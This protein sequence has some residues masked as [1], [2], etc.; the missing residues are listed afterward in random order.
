MEKYRA[1]V[2]KTFPVSLLLEDKDCLIVGGGQGIARKLENMIHSGARLTLISPDLS[3]STRDIINEN[4]ISWI[5][6]EFV[7]ADLE[8]RDLVYTGT[9][10]TE[11]NKKVLQECKKRRILCCP[12]DRNWP[13]GDFTTPAIFRKDELS[14]AVSTGGASCRRSKLI[15][16]SLAKHVDMI[17]SAQLL[18]IGTSHNHLDLEKREAFHLND[19]AIEKTG[20]MLNHVWGV[21]EFLILNTCNRI[22]ILAIVSNDKNV[23]SL[24]KRILGFDALNQDEYYIHA[25]EKAFH[26]SST[27]LAGLYSQTPGENHIV[28]QVKDALTVSEKMGWAGTILKDWISRSLGISKKIRNQTGALLKDLEIED[29]ALDYIEEMGPGKKR[30]MILGTGVI[31][32][33]VSERALKKGHSLISCYYRNNPYK[34]D[35]RDI[36]TIPLTDF[37]ERLKDID[38]LIAAT[39]SQNFLLNIEDRS[40]FRDSGKTILIDLSLPRNISPALEDRGENIQI[41]DLDD[42][43]H[44]FRREQADMKKIMTICS[45]LLQENRESY[46]RITSSFES[47]KS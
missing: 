40:F 15:K 45:N 6:R 22:E 4:S 44:W 35:S 5:E 47:R 34:G 21:H 24:I 16:Q 8:G 28:A 20:M 12:I 29:V 33:G 9:S 19:D 27:L 1:L 46:D 11:L 18:V 43:K 10:D 32:R 39:G 41:A 3:Q 36:E 14:I 17:D 37:K 42:L 25:E 30:G 31:A 26:H 38:Y 23:S 7:I 2:K 13:E